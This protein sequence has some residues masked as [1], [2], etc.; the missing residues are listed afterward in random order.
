VR[1]QSLFRWVLVRLL[2]MCALAIVLLLIL[3]NTVVRTLQQ[4]HATERLRLQAEQ[5]RAIVTANPA[6]AALAPGADYLQL[7]S[8]LAQSIGGRVALIAPDGR[9]LG[10]SEFGAHT[11][12]DLAALP[13]VAQALQGE[14]GLYLERAGPNRLHHVAAP[15]RTPEGIVGIVRLSRPA[16]LDLSYWG[17][18]WRL[19][20]LPGLLL[21][22]LLAVT[23]WLISRHLAAHAQFVASRLR[24]LGEGDLTARI[25]GN[26]Y[27]ET[28]PIAAAFESAAV[29]LERSI[30]ALLQ[31]QRQWRAL[32]TGM[33]EGLIAVD[34]D[35]NVI[36]LNPAARV[37]L[38]L[39]DELP[40][41][42]APLFRAVRNANLNHFV[43][44]TLRS[45]QPHLER[46]IELRQGTGELLVCRLS[47]VRFEYR[48]GVAP[49]VLVLMHDVTHLRRLENM[50][51]EFVAN[52]SHELKTPITAI[53]G[54]VET[55]R[56]CLPDSPAQA[57]RFAGIVVQQADRLNAIVDDLLTLSRLEQAGQWVAKDFEARDLR[58]TVEQ[59][60]RLCEPKAQSRRVT[61][62]NEV[63]SFTLYANHRLLEQAITN[64]IDNAVKYGPEG[65]PVTL[66]F[67]VQPHTVSLSV[68][69]RGVGID[70][71]HHQRI[72]ERFYRVDKSR[73]RQT[74]GTGLGLAIV[75][76]I[77]RVHGGK[78]TVASTPGEGATFTLSLP[79]RHAAPS[80]V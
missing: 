55:I 28:Q 66:R 62:A 54:F 61:I 71:I 36:K 72:F 30:G 6:T 67:T 45:E 3:L 33:R 14:L 17:T 38:G 34:S 27:A 1:P 64:L 44:E 51:K 40:L 16:A 19:V 56:D 5:L 8:D 2:A 12:P 31:D 65:Q 42:G 24:R 49:G 57:A 11:L 58:V 37:L 50:R 78:V 75:K 53:R 79:R 77:M 29:H 41:D 73:D 76:H 74:G 7:C 52:V 68:V 18:V 69:D 35:L 4:D 39:S 43:H 46:E 47:G 9:V 80:A 21:L 48:P 23:A 70:P 26:P 25:S 59:A 32:F 20:W 22:A 10:D 13:D 15:L 60:I 63:P